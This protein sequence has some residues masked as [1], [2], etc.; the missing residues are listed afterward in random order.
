[1]FT[2]DERAPS[3]SFLDQGSDDRQIVTGSHVLGY[4]AFRVFYPDVGALGPAIDVIFLAVDDIL[5]RRA[6][7]FFDVD[8]GAEN[9]FDS[10]KADLDMKLYIAL[11]VGLEGMRADLIAMDEIEHIFGLVNRVRTVERRET[12]IFRGI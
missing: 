6:F 2:V 1:M 3:S 8:V 4:A 9:L 10:C 5:F 7:A 11:P 12:P